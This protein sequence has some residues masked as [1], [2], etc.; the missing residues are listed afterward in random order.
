MI[1]RNR[2][3]NKVTKT[4]VDDEIEIGDHVECE[5]Y[6]VIVKKYGKLVK[7]QHYTYVPRDHLASPTDLAFDSEAHILSWTAASPSCFA[8]TFYILCKE[9]NDKVSR[10]FSNTT[11]WKV[12]GPLPISCQVSSCPKA[13]FNL[14]CSP[15]SESFDF[16]DS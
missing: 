6:A 7:Y 8:P 10:D 4:T 3:I 1:I 9:E 5:R 15:L 13:A 14:S 2:D 12:K 11:Q 16:G